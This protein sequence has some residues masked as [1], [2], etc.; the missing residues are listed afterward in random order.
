MAVFF[1]SYAKMA[2]QLCVICIGFPWNSAT[3][4]PDFQNRA[5]INTYPGH[6]SQRGTFMY[7]PCCVQCI[8]AADLAWFVGA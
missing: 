4:V 8:P 5:E 7:V 1:V 2:L 6:V 3:C